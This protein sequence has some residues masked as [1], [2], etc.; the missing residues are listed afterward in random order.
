MSQTASVAPQPIRPHE[1]VETPWG[2]SLHAEIYADGV[3]FHQTSSHGGFHLDAERNA[4]VDAR[5]RSASG[6]YEEDVQWAIVAYTFPEIFS[7]KGLTV[8]EAPLIHY[9][10]DEFE[11][12]AG[13][14]I[15]PGQSN[16]RDERLFAAEHVGDFVVASAIISMQNPGQIEVLARRSRD[17]TEKRF[18]VPAAEY[19]QR[20]KFGF[21]IDLARHP[22]Y[23]GPSSFLGFAAR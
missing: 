6:W 9:Y 11:A 21:A 10:P 12:I 4:M 22:Q 23:D 13:R 8:S 7:Q 19:E 16:A 3:V 2:P 14:Q 20:R 17:G 18:L 15:A 5:W 1:I